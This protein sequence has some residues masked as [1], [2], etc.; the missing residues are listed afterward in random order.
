MEWVLYPERF[1]HPL[2]Y[3]CVFLFI[4]KTAFIDCPQGSSSTAIP[5]KLTIHVDLSSEIRAYGEKIAKTSIPTVSSRPTIRQWTRYRTFGVS[6][7]VLVDGEPFVLPSPHLL[8]C[9]L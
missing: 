6:H 1:H 9:L 3:R 5:A 2:Q 8:R 4:L 7:S